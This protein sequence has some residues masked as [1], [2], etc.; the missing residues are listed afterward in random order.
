MVGS[1]SV[2]ETRPGDR[3][4][5]ARRL[6]LALG[7]KSLTAM[8]GKVKKKPLGG[9]KWVIWIPVCRVAGLKGG[10]GEFPRHQPLCPE[11]RRLCDAPGARLRLLARNGNRD[12]KSLGQTRCLRNKLKRQRRQQGFW[13]LNTGFL[14]SWFKR[15]LSGRRRRQSY[16]L[17]LQ[18]DVN[19]CIISAVT[20][21]VVPTPFPRPG[22]ESWPEFVGFK[23][24]LFKSIFSLLAYLSQAASSSRASDKSQESAGILEPEL[25]RVDV[26]QP[27]SPHISFRRERS[28]PAALTWER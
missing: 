28:D 3:F 19:G 23:A 10:E 20:G 15:R 12:G 21:N 18:H 13:Y 8:A 22:Q 7:K 25:D 11:R 17:V 4:P 24:K 14:T 5:L 1:E 6:E 2:G 9:R 26:S 27:A 16:R